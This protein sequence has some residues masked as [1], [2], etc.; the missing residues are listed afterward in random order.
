MK[1]IVGIFAIVAFLL[2]FAG[3]VFL[4]WAWPIRLGIREAKKK[5]YSPAWMWFGV[6]PLGGWITYAVLVCQR[7]R[8]RC[9]SCGGFAKDNFTRCPFCHE[10]IVTA[11]A[12]Q[13]P[14]RV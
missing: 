8:I 9:G 4:F 3:V 13:S 12:Q 1:I 6:H 10:A 5:N 7:P 14:P 11:G 2:V